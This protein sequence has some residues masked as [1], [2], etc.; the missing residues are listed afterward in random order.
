M[1]FRTDREYLALSRES[2]VDGLKRIDEFND[3]YNNRSILHLSE[4]FK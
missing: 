4:I 3:D 2:I 1:R